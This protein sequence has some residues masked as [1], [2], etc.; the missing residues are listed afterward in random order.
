MYHPSV[1]SAVIGA[2]FPWDITI[3]A[4]STLIAGIGAA[5]ATAWASRSHDGR[6]WKLDRQADAA[7]DL[8]RAAVPLYLA[9]RTKYVTKEYSADGL[10]VAASKVDWTDWNG[11]LVRLGI[12]AEP[13]LATAARAWDREVWLLSGSLDG[14]QVVNPQEWSDSVVGYQKAQIAFVNE[15]RR[16]LGHDE[17]VSAV[18]GKPDL[19]ETE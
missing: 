11:A 15:A 14:R 12:V 13:D 6:R 10:S 7:A 3:T 18:S 2:A 17:P 16:V 4:A 9:M 8:L 1:L 5:I 19:G